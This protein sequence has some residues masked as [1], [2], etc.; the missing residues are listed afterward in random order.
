MKNL[1]LPLTFFLSSMSIASIAA[2]TGQILVNTDLKSEPFA[3]AKTLAS[4]PGNSTVDVLKCQGGWMQ[5]KPADNG[6]GWVK[7]I[8][9][10]LGGAATGTK[11]DSG[12]TALWNTAMQGRS[13]NTGVTVATG[14]R[15]LSPEDMKNANPSPDA[16][17]KL[18]NYAATKSQAESA[19][20]GAKLSKQNI[21]YLAD[22]GGKK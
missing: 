5:V 7:M 21:D 19:A 2:E 22:A 9:V 3:D 10:K 16:V 15:G 20:K 4:L 18:D 8:A 13:G 14:V 17:K 11:G 6:Q 12:M 1:S